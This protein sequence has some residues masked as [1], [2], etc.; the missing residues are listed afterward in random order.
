MATVVVMTDCLL[1]LRLR[2]LRILFCVV[3]VRQVRATAPRNSP[4]WHSV[5]L[6][7]AATALSQ[8]IEDMPLYMSSN[9]ARQ[10]SKETPCKRGGQR[11]S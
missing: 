4:S 5:S 6:G 2:L 9:V 10:Y 3:F 11:S 8:V 7:A 1:S